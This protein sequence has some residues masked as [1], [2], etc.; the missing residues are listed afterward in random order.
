MGNDNEKNSYMWNVSILVQC[1]ALLCML[2]TRI[3]TQNVLRVVYL[4]AYCTSRDV[5]SYFVYILVFWTCFD[6]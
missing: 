6:L 2:L 3:A 5:I 4:K 1:Y